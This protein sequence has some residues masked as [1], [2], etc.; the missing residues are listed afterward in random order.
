MRQLSDYAKR[1]PESKYSRY[2]WV[3]QSMFDEVLDELS[4]GTD[5]AVIASWF[6]QFGKIVEWCGSGNDSVLPP[7]VR[8]YLTEQL[9]LTTGSATALEAD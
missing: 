1:G 2:L 6:E 5:D 7:N 9:A 3:M 4:D 8:G